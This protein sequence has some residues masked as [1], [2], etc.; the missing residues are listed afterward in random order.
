MT[1]ER[2]KF[3]PHILCMAWNMR[4]ATRPFGR[5]FYILH[6]ALFI[7]GLSSHVTGHKP[8]PPA[9]SADHSSFFLCVLGAL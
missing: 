6:F 8:L 7:S 2:K 3:S 5:S 1:V 4:P 9:P